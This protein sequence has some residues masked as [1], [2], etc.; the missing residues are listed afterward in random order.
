MVTCR[1]VTV[2]HAS[3]VLK[4]DTQTRKPQGV[5][6]RTSSDGDDPNNKPKTS[7]RNYNNSVRSSGELLE[8]GK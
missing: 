4:A 2:T 8:D 6:I 1:A 3:L 5:S 7:K